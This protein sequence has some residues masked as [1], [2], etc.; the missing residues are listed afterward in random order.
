MKISLLIISISGLII[1]LL[2]PILQMMGNVSPTLGKWGIQV[3]TVLW[4]AA[5]PFLM[6][7]DKNATNK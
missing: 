5:A 4:F 3:G 7:A 1:M 2:L 6:R